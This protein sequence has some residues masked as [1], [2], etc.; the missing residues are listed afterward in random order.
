MPIDLEIGGSSMDLTTDIGFANCLYHAANLR[1]GG[2]CMAAPVC[3]SFVFMKRGVYTAKAFVFLD[4]LT[5]LRH[6]KSY[7]TIA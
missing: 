3:G 5:G 4:A 2:A 7:F 1:E 6:Q